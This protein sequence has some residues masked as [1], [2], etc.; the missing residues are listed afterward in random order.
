MVA[1]LLVTWRDADARRLVGSGSKPFGNASDKGLLG[2]V[3]CPK[4]VV[5]VVAAVVAGG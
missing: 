2:L 3:V 5:V 1:V 4:V